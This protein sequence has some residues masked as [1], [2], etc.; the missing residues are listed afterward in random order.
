M[1]GASLKEAILGASGK[2]LD[3]FAN[4]FM[5]GAALCGVGSVVSGLIKPPASEAG[6]V[7]NVGSQ[8]Q[9]AV[10]DAWKKEQQAVREGV[11]RYEW[12]AAEMTELMDVGKI[13]GYKGH[14]ILS[15]NQLKGT[16]NE[17]LI[18]SADDIVFLNQ[19]EHFSVHMGNW[20]NATNMDLLVEL[21]PGFAETV[22]ELLKMAA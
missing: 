16:A 5:I 11:S 4:G 20:S 7:F 12:T 2:G 6:D 8:R 18:G 21:R 10:A 1:N 19:A 17:W 9:K 13:S 14:H 15:V 22:T 3:S